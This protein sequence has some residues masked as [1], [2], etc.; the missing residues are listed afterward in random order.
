MEDWPLFGGQLLTVP[1][2]PATA[3]PNGHVLQDWSH[4]PPSQLLSRSP[5]E[6]ILQD[7][8]WLDFADVEESAE[9]T[10]SWKKESH[11]LHDVDLPSIPSESSD[12]YFSNNEISDVS[13]VDS[14]SATDGS[15]DIYIHD[16]DSHSSASPI[17]VKFEYGDI[18]SGQALDYTPTLNDYTQFQ[19]VSTI[20]SNPGVFSRLPADLQT[21]QPDSFLPQ[22][23]Q[24]RFYSD[25]DGLDCDSDCLRDPEN[26]YKL[27]MQL[28]DSSS[29]S[30]PLTHRPILSPVSPEE[31]DSVLSPDNSASSEA[32][33]VSEIL[34]MTIDVAPLVERSP[35][36]AVIASAIVPLHDYARRD[37]ALKAE[38][39]LSRCSTPAEPYSTEPRSD[40]RLKKK[41]QNKT[42]ALRYRRK[43]REEK[44]VVLTE[45]EELELKNNKL[46]ARADDLTREISYLRGLLEEIKRQ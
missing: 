10:D 34:Q 6:E 35:S 33:Q 36:P 7:S 39:S 29:A 18:F 13:V 4:E 12:F 30:S 25:L 5:V 22:D 8:I 44:G 14:T 19:P 9:L 17:D 15:F 43:K 1:D 31:V 26:V 37:V 23:T 2:T 45:V 46:K 38:A 40:R 3:D 42:A 32:L 21:F 41:E 16:N 28:A 11:F 27:L 20:S 24:Y